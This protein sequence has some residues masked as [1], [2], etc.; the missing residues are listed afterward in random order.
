MDGTDKEELP[1]RTCENCIC[2]DGDY[3]IKNWN[4]ADRD[5]LIPWRDERDPEETCEDWEGYK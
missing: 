2:F 1:V 4:N 3:C 5:Y